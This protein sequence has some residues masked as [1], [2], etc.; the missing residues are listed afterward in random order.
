[1]NKLVHDKRFQ[2]IALGLATAALLALIWYGLIQTIRSG[3]R[4]TADRISLMRSK[5]DPAKRSTRLADQIKADLDAATAKLLTAE[6][7]MVE[8]DSFRWVINTLSKYQSRYTIEFK[9]YDP[10]QGGELRLLPKVPYRAASFT[11]S[12]TATYHDFGR[13]LADFENTEP[14]VRLQRL[15]LEPASAVNLTRDEDNNLT[16]RM[17]FVTLAKPTSAQP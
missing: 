11:V 9:E 2:L 5:V 17:E 8:G 1:M 12:G 3:L 4:D 14:Y 6:V 13:F 10:P 16:F 7:S 15:E